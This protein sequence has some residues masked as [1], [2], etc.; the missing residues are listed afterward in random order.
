MWP[1]GQSMPMSLV[2]GCSAE[3]LEVVRGFT[4]WV[5]TVQQQLTP[6]P[7]TGPG[8]TSQQDTQD[9]GGAPS[10]S[11]PRSCPLLG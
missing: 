4:L 5:L 2:P 9:D 11:T 10:G 6:G 1:P 3:G 7:V 8:D